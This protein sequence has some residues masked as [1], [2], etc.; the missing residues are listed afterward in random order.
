M[1]ALL[2]S[3]SKV[4][5]MTPSYQSLYE[6]A[7]SNGCEVQFWE[8]HMREDGGMEYRVQDVLVSKQ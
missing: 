5:A 8:P 6:L 1:K 7:D 3:G 2:S 4:I